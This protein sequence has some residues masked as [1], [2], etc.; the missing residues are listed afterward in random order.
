MTQAIDEAARQRALDIYRVV[1]SLPEAAYDDIV[2]I[3][4]ALCDVPVALVSLIDRDRQWFKAST[5]F[6]LSEG[7]RDEA[8]CDHAI[9]CPDQLM[10]VPDATADSRFADNPLVTGDTGIRFYAGMPLVTP[11]GAAV[12]TVCVIDN[13]PRILTDAQRDA[14][15]ALAR[16]TINLFEGRHRDIVLERARVLG[17]RPA[18]EAEPAHRKC[19]VAIFEMQSLAAEARRIGERALQR[20]QHRLIEVLDAVL[21]AGCSVNHASHSAEFIA[22]LQT[23]DN[24]SAFDALKRVAADFEQ[25]TGLR[26]MAASAEEDYPDERP[27]NIFVRADEQL[28][29]AKDE[30]VHAAAHA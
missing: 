7:R 12:G 2:R 1:D 16:L 6:S 4:A 5:G 8:F 17:Q 25:A 26:L 28:S 30:A 11:G 13:E 29:R 24:A 22:V 15:A 23:A 3:A 18:S 10:E 27:E 21:P 20:E 19:M 9:R 14:L